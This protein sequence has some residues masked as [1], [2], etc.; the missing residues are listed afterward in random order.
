MGQAGHIGY[1]ALFIMHTCRAR[2]RR[3]A[4]WPL[5]WCDPTGKGS[6][7]CGEVTAQLTA[8]F[9]GHPYL[10]FPAQAVSNSYVS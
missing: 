2:L 10:A 3:C 9:Q 4:V 8:S 7:T 6:G 5:A 1:S